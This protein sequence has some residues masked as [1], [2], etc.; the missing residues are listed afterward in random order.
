M[1]V[2]R[3]NVSVYLTMSA[4]VCV[5]VCARECVMGG[6]T[7]ALEQNRCVF[8]AATPFPQVLE[9]HAGSARVNALACPMEVEWLLFLFSLTGCNAF[10]RTFLQHC[11]SFTT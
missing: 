1:E 10:L 7:R 3:E 5:R 11:F 9:L 6:V 8:A 2:H 4:S